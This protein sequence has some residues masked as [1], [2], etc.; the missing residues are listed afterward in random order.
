MFR[1]LR[2]VENAARLT[3]HDEKKYRDLNYNLPSAF[4]RGLG[5]LRHCAAALHL[6]LERLGS[7]FYAHTLRRGLLPLYSAG[8]YR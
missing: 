5:P 8:S 3:T 6:S 7:L 2:C 4:F 1:D